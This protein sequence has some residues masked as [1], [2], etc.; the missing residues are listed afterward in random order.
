M[1][2]N[3]VIES[4]NN[5]VIKTFSEMVSLN[6]KKTDNKAD[7]NFTN[8][9]IVMVE[10]LHP[11]STKL[12]LIIPDNFKKTVAEN[13]FGEDISK[14][15]KNDIEDSIIEILNVM[16]GQFIDSI[17]G[18]SV[19]Y[20]INLPKVISDFKSNAGYDSFY[21]DAG[22]NIFCIMIDSAL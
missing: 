10:I 6:I 8:A 22:G 1:Q 21:Y 19:S 7:I 20:K 18:E 3:K 9:V 11:G 5:S 16:S 12:F 14:L 15:S 4:L 2:Q 17:Y 13:I